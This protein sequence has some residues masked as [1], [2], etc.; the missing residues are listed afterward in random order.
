MV[1]A[2]DSGVLTITLTSFNHFPAQ[3]RA[4][5]RFSV[6]NGASVYKISV[7]LSHKQI[8]HLNHSWC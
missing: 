7:I 8:V 3:L 2:E 6:S 1:L 4:K 5:E